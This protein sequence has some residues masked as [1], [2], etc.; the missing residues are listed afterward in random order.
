[1]HN[2]A[3]NAFLH[4]LR[5]GCIVAAAVAFLGAIATAIALPAHPTHDGSAVVAASRVQMPG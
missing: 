3:I 4:G 2:A 5:A 1:V